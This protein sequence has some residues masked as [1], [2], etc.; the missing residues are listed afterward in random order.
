MAVLVAI[1]TLAAIVWV[2]G[3]FFAYSCLRPSV[4]PLAPPQRCAL[5]HAVLGRFFVA[6][7][8]CVVT[9]LASGYAMAFGVLGGM[10]SVGMHVHLMQAV[11]WLMI[12]LFGYV[13]LAPFGE[14]RRAVR[15]EDW[16]DAGS[17][18]ARIRPIV[19]INLVLGLLVSAIAVSGR[20]W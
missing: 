16:P 15:N 11:G 3:M 19:A 20:W 14:L 7:W 17:Q 18:V 2:G 4:A 13:Y 10:R 5:W 1:H 12:A 9:L 6:V 8:V